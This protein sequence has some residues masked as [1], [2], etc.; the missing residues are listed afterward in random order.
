MLLVSQTTIQGMPW[1]PMGS[2]GTFA[3]VLSKHYYILS[4]QSC[5]VN[6][7]LESLT[8]FLH[9]HAPALG[10]SVAIILSDS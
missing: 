10:L 2:C 6:L 5:K 4:F 1:H 9:H 7:N 8:Y 3:L